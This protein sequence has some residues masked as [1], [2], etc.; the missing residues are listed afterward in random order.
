VGVVS[1]PDSPRSARF[2]QPLWRCELP[3]PECFV[4]LDLDIDPDGERQAIEDVIAARL[5]SLGATGSEA[6]GDELV[7]RAVEALETARRHGAIGAAIT[8]DLVDGDA[9]EASLLMFCARGGHGPLTLDSL[10]GSLL[11]TSTLRV[12]YRTADVIEL[13]GRPAVR[14]TGFSLVAPDADTSTIVAEH[15]Y[16]VPIAGTETQLVLICWTPHVDAADE[17]GALFDAI[18]A[19]V[20]VS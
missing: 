2:A 13:G 8:A 15:L 6:L 7:G 12:G 14:G 19:G 9:V 17:F 10:A 4:P 5:A 18:A 11:G 1:A 3:L 16:V 20:R